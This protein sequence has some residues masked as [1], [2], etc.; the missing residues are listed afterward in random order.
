V[1]RTEPSGKPTLLDPET[2]TRIGNLE[3]VARRVV[4]GFLTGLH[5]SSM[6][7]FSTEFDQFRPYAQGDDLKHVD[8]KI[9]AR[10]DRYFVKEYEADRNLD[11]QLLVDTSRSMDYRGAG[12]AKFRY[13][14]MLAASL[15]YLLLRQ[16]DRV[17][18]RLL[19]EGAP[20]AMSPAC[21]P[22]QL[23]R[24]VAALETVQPRGS[25]DLGS[26]LEAVVSRRHRP[27]LV[28]LISDLYDEP[29]SLRR[30][31]AVLRQ[32]GH[33]V[34]VFHLL[35]PE[36]HHFPFRGA[37]QFVDMETGES[38]AVEASQARD[39]YLQQMRSFLESTRDLCA[40]C[41]ATYLRLDTGASLAGSLAAFL[42]ARSRLRRA[43]IPWR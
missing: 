31:L 20:A 11:T 2:L 43:G 15:A 13:A 1:N 9:F 22:G 5:R 21:R 27:G 33:E 17:G 24:V 42:A 16:R 38:L 29:D 3:L 26:S 39:A 6:R 35:D 34:L 40:G 28:A 30:G 12:L 4:E 36:E 8:W 7:G 32:A 14:G 37:L 19:G 18:L 25:A 41:G 10:T 23:Q